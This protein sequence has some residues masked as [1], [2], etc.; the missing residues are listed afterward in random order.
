MSMSKIKKLEDE[1][2]KLKE[3]LSLKEEELKMEISK[4]IKQKCKDHTWREVLDNWKN[5]F[6]LTMPEYAKDMPG[7]MWQTLPINKDAT[8]IYK[9]QFKESS[10]N[11]PFDT[12]TYKPYMTN[13][14]DAG[15]IFLNKSGD[16]L[17]VVPNYKK[18]KNFAHLKNFMLNADISQQKE[19]WKLVAEAIESQLDELNDDD[20]LCVSTHGHGISY[21]HVRI[22]I[23]KPKYYDPAKLIKSKMDFYC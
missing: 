10:F 16:T 2:M 4:P 8:S 15:F 11:Q 14:T 22:E 12:K 6:Y 17:L 13:T 1:I 5:G 20:V 3:Q 23:N 18:G 21:L 7:F 19:F 9:A